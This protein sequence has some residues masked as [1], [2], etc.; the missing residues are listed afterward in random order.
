MI[1]SAILGTLFIGGC[2]AFGPFTSEPEIPRWAFI[3]ILASLC[4]GW[5]AVAAFRRVIIGNLD[6][7]VLMLF[8]WVA[9]SVTWSSDYQGGVYALARAAAIITVYFGV[10]HAPE[11][12][13][14]SI[15]R[16]CVPTVILTV[17]A[18]VAFLPFYE[19]LNIPSGALVMTISGNFYAGFWLENFVTEFLMVAA[20]LML[21]YMAGGWKS[22]TFCVSVL[23]AAWI[24]ALCVRGFLEWPVFAV[25]LGL[26]VI[27]A[28][29]I[30]KWKGALI[31][32]GGAIVIG[33]VTWNLSPEIQSSFAVRFQLWINSLYLIADAPIFG[34]GLASFSGLIDGYQ[35]AHLAI[36]PSLMDQ[37]SMQGMFAGAAHNEFLQLWAEFGVVGVVLAVF[38]A[39]EALLSTVPPGWQSRWFVMGAYW[40]LMSVIALSMLGFPLQQPAPAL[41]AAVS[42]GI[43]GRGQVGAIVT[44]THKYGIWQGLAFSAIAAGLIASLVWVGSASYQASHHMSMFRA[45]W[46]TDKFRAASENIAAYNIFPYDQFVRRQL[47]NSIAALSASRAVDIDRRSADLL[48]AVGRSAA[49]YSLDARMARLEYLFN[50]KRWG[51]PETEGLLA[52]L[53]DQYPNRGRVWVADAFYAAFSGDLMRMRASATMAL[54][55]RPGIETRLPA[56][57]SLVAAINKEFPQ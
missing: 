44:R 17:V 54:K 4:A 47:P 27:M 12:L 9:L 7:T 26:I 45:W 56:F 24:T 2:L 23:L 49:P 11:N 35:N 20:P 46:D 43:L 33:V 5:L 6:I 3:Y 15:M 52:E 14:Y 25:S 50:S 36:W 31:L 34:H 1:W 30:P 28:W 37:L 22:R 40:S 18:L 29:K 21:I 55:I 32:A 48:Y 38:V 16:W 8:L 10:R 39:R 57:R 19:G 53:R 41:L 51:E 13:L 42:L